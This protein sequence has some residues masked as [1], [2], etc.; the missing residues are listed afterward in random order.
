MFGL[1]IHSWLWLCTTV[2]VLLGTGW[3][4]WNAGRFLV[5]N[6]TPRASDAIIVLGGGPINRIEKASQL[7]AQG[8]APLLVASGGTMY[9]ATRSQAE[10]MAL[11]A[12][13]LG[14]PASHIVLDQKS[15]STQQNARDTLA[16]LLRRHLRSAIVVSSDYHMRRVQWLFT[17][18]YRGHHIRLIYV[19]A[20]DPWF[21]P[22]RWWS[23]PRSAFLTASEYLKLLVAVTLQR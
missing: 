7:Y 21:R 13:Q 16:I 22:T 14:V 10:E 6:Q 3:A 12:E 23:N 2:L 1:R 18:T 19:A 9:S 5:V 15:E 4:L 11:Q 20:S 17:H 8:Y